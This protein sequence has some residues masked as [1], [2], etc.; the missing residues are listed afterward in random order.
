MEYNIY[1]ALGEFQHDYEDDYHLEYLLTNPEL[2]FLQYLSDISELYLEL[3]EES[4]NT[5]VLYKEEFEQNIITEKEYYELSE[6]NRK[7]RHAWRQILRFIKRKMEREKLLY[8]TKPKLEDNKI[9]IKGSIQSIGYIFSELI[10]KGHIQPPKRNGKI[11]TSAISR[12]ILRHFEFVDREVQPNPE[13]I[14]KTLFS[15]NKLS[16]DKQAL[17]KI[18][19]NKIINTD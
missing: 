4:I 14:R 19:Q 3:I 6:N 17:F 13:D 2:T 11:N 9:K 16:A 18:P 12:L 8:E 7:I 10:D 1:Q 15:E 5:S